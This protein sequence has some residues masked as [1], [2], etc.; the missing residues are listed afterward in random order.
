MTPSTNDKLFSRVGLI[1]GKNNAV[2]GSTELSI[3]L[4]VVTMAHLNF[5]AQPVG[6]LRL[7]QIRESLR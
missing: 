3:V 4:M 5:L 2:D 1:L 6:R 7:I